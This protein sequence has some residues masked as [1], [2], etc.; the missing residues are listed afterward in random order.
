MSREPFA[1]PSLGCPRPF[2]RRTAHKPLRTA[3]FRIR[4]F[5]LA[6]GSTAVDF[7][8]DHV[9]MLFPNL[10][11]NMADAS[12]DH[13]RVVRSDFARTAFSVLQRRGAP[14]G[15]S[16]GLYRELECRGKGASNINRFRASG[17][18]LCLV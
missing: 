10:V 4:L 18:R 7:P 5:F 11:G 9:M 1:G 6:I 3:L 2:R 12:A 13:S 17:L 8:A 14:V 15:R 16:T